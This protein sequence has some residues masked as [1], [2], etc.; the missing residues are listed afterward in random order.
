MIP[1]HMRPLF[2]DVNPDDFDPA[3]YPRYTIE[4]ILEH[5]E[6]ADVAW[7]LRRFSRE[8]IHEVLR[9]D[10]RLSA[11]SAHFWALVF[12]L[13]TGEVAALLRDG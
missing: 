5:G 9:T 7:L 2:W 1:A 13:P 10:R 6:E 3:A 4:R 12:E 8:Q 11:R